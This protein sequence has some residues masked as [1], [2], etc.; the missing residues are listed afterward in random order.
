M[1]EVA[2]CTSHISIKTYKGSV[3]ISQVGLIYIT[4]L[5]WLTKIVFQP[6]IYKTSQRLGSELISVAM[7][8]AVYMMPLQKV[9]KCTEQTSSHLSP[10]FGCFIF[11]K[12]M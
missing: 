1:K 11:F 5:D 10:A 8:S 9:L 2:H 6:S 12:L 3:Y 7:V 4:E